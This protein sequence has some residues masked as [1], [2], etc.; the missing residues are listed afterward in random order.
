MKPWRRKDDE[1]IVCDAVR[2]NEDNIELVAQTFGIELVEEL[3]KQDPDVND[4]QYG[5]NV[6]TPNGVQRASLGM[7]LVKFAKH[8]FVYHVR[9]FEEV[10]EPVDRPSPPPESIGDA[11]MARGMDP[12]TGK[13][14]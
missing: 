13:R 6:R 1:T 5:L 9:P 11:Y 2:L 10:Y 12:A 4:K 7:Y 8:L 3:N 14:I